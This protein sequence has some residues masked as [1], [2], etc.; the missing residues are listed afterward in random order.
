MRAH[1]TRAAAG[2]FGVA[3]ILLGA[4]AIDGPLMFYEEEMIL[5]AGFVAAGLAAWALASSLRP[6]SALGS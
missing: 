4:A 3:A 1:L 6:A 5:A 2:C